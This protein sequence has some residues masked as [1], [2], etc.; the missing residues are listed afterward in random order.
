MPRNSV[1]RPPSA[2]HLCAKTRG[3]SCALKEG[4]RAAELAPARASIAFANA[5]IRCLLGRQDEALDLL[6]RAA[7]LGY[8]R[9]DIENDPDAA[10]ALPRY[11]RI[12][13]LAG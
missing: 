11:R 7:R 12:V 10:C 3:D 8:A 9:D 1:P 4:A 5:V 2:R 13:E 6:E